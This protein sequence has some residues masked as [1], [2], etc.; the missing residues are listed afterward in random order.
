M[1]PVGEVVRPRQERRVTAWKFNEVS[2]N[3]G[4]GVVDRQASGGEPL[5]EAEIGCHRGLPGDLTAHVRA[6]R[7]RAKLY[8]P[9]AAMPIAANINSMVLG[10]APR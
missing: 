4:T 2:S 6:Q 5:V 9:K 10:W 8:R 7:L 3:R 1:E